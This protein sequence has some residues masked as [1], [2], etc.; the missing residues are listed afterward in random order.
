VVGLF[1]FRPTGFHGKEHGQ[2]FRA[3]IP[4]TI[5]RSGPRQSD[6]YQYSKSTRFVKS[7]KLWSREIQKT[8]L[9]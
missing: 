8:H 4:L 5:G 9:K 6:S 7:P 1:S 2:N 3:R